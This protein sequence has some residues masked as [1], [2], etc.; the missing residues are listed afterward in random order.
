MSHPWRQ[1]A[2]KF[3]KPGE[4]QQAPKIK[5]TVHVFVSEMVESWSRIE[6]YNAGTRKSLLDIPQKDQAAWLINLLKKA[7]LAYENQD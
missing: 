2:V 7:Y 6:I 1:Y 3:A 4:Q 5:K